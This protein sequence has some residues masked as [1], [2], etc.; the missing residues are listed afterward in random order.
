MFHESLRT[1]KQHSKQIRCFGRCFS[2][3]GILGSRQRCALPAEVTYYHRGAPDS[4]KRE[5]KKNTKIA[6]RGSAERAPRF[7]DEVFLHFIILFLFFFKY[8]A[9]TASYRDYSGCLGGEGGN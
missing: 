2:I 4:E 1:D 5:Q 9:L 6:S 8:L 7:V 3:R